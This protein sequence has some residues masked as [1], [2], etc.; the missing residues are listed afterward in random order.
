MKKNYEFKNVQFND[1]REY[2]IQE[3]ETK[4]SEAV[5]K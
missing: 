1:E 2:R 3:L 4:L 5:K